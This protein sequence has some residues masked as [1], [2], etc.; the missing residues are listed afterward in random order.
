[1]NACKH[2]A[3]RAQ[4]MS[5]DGG[6]CGTQRY[7]ATRAVPHLKSLYAYAPKPCSYVKGCLG[8]PTP[9]EYKALATEREALRRELEEAQ[10]TIAQ[11]QAKV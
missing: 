8:G 10:Q 11:L 1:M 2:G 3:C 7:P 9:D 5:H 4:H 6:C